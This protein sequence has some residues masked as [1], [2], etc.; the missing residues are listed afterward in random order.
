MK[1][2]DP[3]KSMKLGTVEGNRF[4]S[5]AFKF[6][7]DVP[8]G[9][10]NFLGDRTDEMLQMGADAVFDDDTQD[11]LRES[12]QQTY[13]VFQY[14]Q[15]P[16]GAAVPFNPNIN[17]VANP[18]PPNLQMT[19]L[20]MAKENEVAL[21]QLSPSIALKTPA[22]EI[23]IDG[24]RVAAIE[25]TMIMNNVQLEQRHIFFESNGYVVDIVLSYVDQANLDV[26]M[27]SVRTLRL[28]K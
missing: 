4:T 2:A 23:D 20:Q 28:E 3:G 1:F 13:A 10:S 6:S 26:M 5:P 18:L 25:I 8:E 12:I 14:G 27:D 7:M 21:P 19:N 24:F 17:T 15:Y 16:L 11:A 22:F 9:W